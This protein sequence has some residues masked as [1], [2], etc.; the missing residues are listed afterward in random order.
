MALEQ[1]RPELRRHRRGV[2][3]GAAEV[4]GRLAVGSEP[5]G[6]FRSERRVLEHRIA[7]PSERGVVC[8]PRRIG[9]V[10]REYRQHLSVQRPHAL[11]LN[12]L[13]HR[14]PGKLVAEADGVG[15]H[16]EQAA[17]AGFVD[18]RLPRPQDRFDEPAFGP[19]R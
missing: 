12:R 17:R 5:R 14:S 18:R 19:P 13:E 1:V 6:L 10:L 7:Q 3:Q 16:L 15:L 9:A 8:Q 4:G 11:G 2:L